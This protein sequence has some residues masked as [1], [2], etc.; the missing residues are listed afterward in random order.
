MFAEEPE[1][2]TVECVV[3]GRFMKA[4]ISRTKISAWLAVG[5]D[6]EQAPVHIRLGLLTSKGLSKLLDSVLRVHVGFA[7][8]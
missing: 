8:K 4:I 7:V 3:L 6:Q 5:V 2:F 1:A